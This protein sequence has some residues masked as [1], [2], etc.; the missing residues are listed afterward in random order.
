M[1]G[2]TSVANTAI[3]STPSALHGTVQTGLGMVRDVVIGAKA[4][5]SAQRVM[6]PHSGL[7]MS[8]YMDGNSR[9][10]CDLFVCPR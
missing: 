6:Q 5:T 1:E 8:L 9:Y 10:A 7:G 4:A 2:F 3:R